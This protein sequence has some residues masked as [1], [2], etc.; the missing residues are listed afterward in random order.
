MEPSLQRRYRLPPRI[1]VLHSLSVQWMCSEGIRVVGDNH[2]ELRPE[3]D[4]LRSAE[5]RIDGIRPP[6]GSMIHF[7]YKVV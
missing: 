7:V 6:K 3:G 2:K 4:G 1:L 5:Q